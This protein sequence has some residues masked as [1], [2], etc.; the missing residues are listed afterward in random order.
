MAPSNITWSTL[1]RTK[2][3]TVV[4]MFSS[5]DGQAAPPLNTGVDLSKGSNPFVSRYSRALDGSKGDVPARCAV[6]HSMR[7]SPTLGGR[8]LQLSDGFT[9]GHL[10]LC[11]IVAPGARFE[12]VQRVARRP[13]NLKL[14]LPASPSGCDE[15]S[16]L[17]SL[18]LVAASRAGPR[19]A[20]SFPNSMQRRRKTVAGGR[21]LATDSMIGR[22]R[23]WR[24]R[25]RGAFFRLH[26]T[27][28][29]LSNF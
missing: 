9:S 27:Y 24:S 28:W 10:A 5:G 17:S 6:L 12:L 26:L 16:P 2:R 25:R 7:P 29:P 20:A 1:S 14:S 18:S 19:R 21:A 22:R 4:S 23:N 8:I 3:L 15:R 13:T 11:G